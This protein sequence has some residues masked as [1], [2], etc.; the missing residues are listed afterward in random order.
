MK[1]VRFYDERD[2]NVIAVSTG[3]RCPDGAYEAIGAVY[4]H[5]DSPVAST[6]VSPDHLRT[7]KRISETVAR[8]IH[9]ALFQRLDS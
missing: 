4:F 6:F 1:G 7:C 8:E 9:P 5:P 2:G 3:E